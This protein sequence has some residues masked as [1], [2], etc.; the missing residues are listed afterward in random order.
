[1]SALTD[2][3]LDALARHARASIEH[4]LGGP[5]PAPPRGD[6]FDRPGATFV[7]VYRADGELQGCI[8]SLEPSR[9]L[10]RDVAHNARAAAIDDPRA[11]PLAPADVPRLAVEV[12]VLSPHAP[13]PYDGTLAGACAALSPGVDGVVLSWNGHRATFL[14]Q[15]WDDVPDPADFLRQLARKAGLPPRVWPAGVTL[16]RYR[17]QKGVSPARAPTGEARA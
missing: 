13:V 10:A 16:E 15:V 1:M 12:S 17:V 9:P 4:A 14:P 11:E 8:G 5:A 7:T 6:V 2:A 3:E